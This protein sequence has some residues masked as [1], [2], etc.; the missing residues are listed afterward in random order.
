MGTHKT[1]HKRKIRDFL[2]VLRKYNISSDPEP[3]NIRLALEELGPAYVKLG[4]IMANRTDVFPAALCEELSNLRDEVEPMTAEEVDRVI[5]DAYGK[6]REELFAFFDEE[7]KGSA[8]IAQVHYARLNSGE[9]AAVKLQRIGAAEEMKTDIAF[10]KSLANKLPFIRKNPYIDANELLDEL[11]NLTQRELD[12]AS[13]ANNLE[14][15]F[16]LNEDVAYVSCPRVYPEFTTSSVIVMEFIRGI[17]ITDREALEAKGYDMNEIGRKYAR[18]FLKQLVEDGFFHADPHAGNIMISDGRIIWYDMG[19]MGEFSPRVI[20][21]IIGLI[22]SIITKDITKGFD[23]FCQTVGMGDGCDKGELFRDLRDLMTSLY[24]MNSGSLDLNA[25]MQKLFQ[26]TKDHHLSFDMSFTAM[27]RGIMNVSGTLKNYFP[28]IDFLEEVKGFAA[29]YLNS[30]Y[31]D[32]N[33]DKSIEF[34]KIKT[35]A[36]KIARIPE[37]LANMVEMY[38]KGLVPIRMEMGVDEK[39]QI[40]IAGIVGVITDALIIAALLVSSSIIVLSRLDP[41]ILGL[42]AL[43]FVGYNTAV[44]IMIIDYVSRP[45]KE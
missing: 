16:K 14:R 8:S 39:S 19:F 32:K 30:S 9:E 33:T 28:D 7:A 2:A 45:K 1:G 17:K 21:Q 12:F 20:S 11:W 10:M 42:P 23:I 35:K 34:L 5:F 26:I 24:D 27:T 44:L 13:E 25:V 22:E 18:N 40:F 31:K 4:Q 6:K 29:D 38:S 36:E 37:N 3:R 15:F 43:S 41:L